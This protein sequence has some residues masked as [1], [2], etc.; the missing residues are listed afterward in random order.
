MGVRTEWKVAHGRRKM[1]NVRKAICLLPLAICLLP[2]RLAAAESP[3][4][5]FKRGN[6]AYAEGKFAEAAS[7]YKEARSAGLHHWALYYNLGNAYFKTGELGEAV[8]N[9]ERAFRLNS[10]QSDVL[11]NLNLASTKAGDSLMP[12][13]ALPALLWQLFYAL[14]I[15]GLTVMASL[16]FL[17]LAAFAVLALLGRYRFRPE[18]WTLLGGAFL[19]LGGWLGARILRLERPEGVVIATVAE[20]RSGPNLSYP[21]NFTIPEGRRVL[22]LEEQEPVAGWIEIGVPQEGLKGW[23]PDASIDVL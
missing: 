20:V 14:S 22:V 13:S 7:L 21:A 16:L 10:G 1:A 5:L 4:D 2:F 17:A 12:T 6:A 18:G 15:N 19:I 9:Y 11:Y 8:A 3:S 23:V